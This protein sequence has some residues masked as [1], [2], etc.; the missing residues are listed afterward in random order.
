MNDLQQSSRTGFKL[1]ILL[2]YDTCLYQQ[3]NKNLCVCVYVCYHGKEMVLET[4]TAVGTI[5][6]SIVAALCMFVSLWID[7]VGLSDKCGLNTHAIM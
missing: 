7:F 5:I 1:Q 6:L 3:A 4:P 2:F